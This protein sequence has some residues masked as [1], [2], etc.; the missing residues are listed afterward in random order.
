MAIVDVD[1]K[2]WG[3]ASP[4]EIATIKWLSQHG[5][6]EW[7]ALIEAWNW[8]LGEYV[9]A[10]IASQ[11]ECDAATALIIYWRANG[12]AHFDHMH[13]LTSDNPDDFDPGFKLA[14]MIA[15]RF[16]QG[17]YPRREVWYDHVSIG[18]DFK[19]Y[20][21]ALKKFP[22]LEALPFM[23]PPPF[24]PPRGARDVDVAYFYAGEGIPLAILKSEHP[25]RSGAYQYDYEKLFKS[26]EE[27]LKKSGRRVTK[28]LG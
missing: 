25:D 17:G 8:D 1:P 18:D 27:G 20:E 23:A 14:R 3:G 13:I 15:R 6:D 10:W 22:D 26:R 7:H 21:R 12:A 9:P 5:P 28:K 11:S 4:K 16:E 19:F 2:E 24:E